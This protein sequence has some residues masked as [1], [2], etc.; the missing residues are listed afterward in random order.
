MLLLG[1]FYS[2]ALAMV[3]ECELWSIG[4]FFCKRFPTDFPRRYTQRKVTILQVFNV[5]KRGWRDDSA[6][7]R[8]HWL[9][10]ERT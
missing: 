1:K 7:R 4:G 9:F 8:E 3:W 2:L 6:V 5:S 10:F